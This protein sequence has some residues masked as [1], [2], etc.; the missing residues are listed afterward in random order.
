MH[1][2]GIDGCKEERRHR[3]SLSRHRGEAHGVE[4]DTEEQVATYVSAPAPAPPTFACSPTPSTTLSAARNIHGHHHA[5]DVEFSFRSRDRQLLNKHTSGLSSARPFDAP[6]R[7]ISTIGVPGPYRYMWSGHPIPKCP[8]SV[9]VGRCLAR[10]DI[11]AF[12][13][14]TYWHSIFV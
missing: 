9:R 3:A 4:E 5:L 7:G 8:I 10:I 1:A 6:S 13:N 2:C 12:I 11:P 14:L